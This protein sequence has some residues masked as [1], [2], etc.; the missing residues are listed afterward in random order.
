MTKYINHKLVYITK[1]KPSMVCKT[2]AKSNKLKTTHQNQ[3]LI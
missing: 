3:Q 1:I 2:I